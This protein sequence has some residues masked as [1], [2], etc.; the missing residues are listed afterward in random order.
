MPAR[1]ATPH[2]RRFRQLKLEHPHLETDELWRMA[3]WEPEGVMPTW[4]ANGSSPKA[5]FYRRDPRERK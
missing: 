4:A 5:A 1:K 2:L 3:G